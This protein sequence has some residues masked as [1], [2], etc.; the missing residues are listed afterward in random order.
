MK[1]VHSEALPYTLRLVL[2][3]L[4]LAWTALG[5]F[6]CK[7]ETKSLDEPTPNIAA[8]QITFATNAPE[9]TSLTV[10]PAQARKATTVGLYGRLAWD[11][12]VTVR[13]H[14]PVAGRVP[15]SY[16]TWDRA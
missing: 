1:N 6:G 2:R 3:A 5:L 16:K 8:D 11:E 14:S 13:I 9:L 10:E 7:P 12:D 15:G 4:L